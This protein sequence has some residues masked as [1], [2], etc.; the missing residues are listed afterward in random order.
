MKNLNTDIQASNRIISIINNSKNQYELIINE[1]ENA[2]V[3]INDKYEILDANQIISSLKKCSFLRENFYS[4]IHIDSQ[5]ELSQVISKC[6]ESEKTL[7]VEGK[8]IDGR[9]FLFTISTLHINRTE[10]GKV[11]K[12]LGTDITALREKEGLI[13]DIFRSV[14]LGMVLIDENSCIMNGYSNFT[15]IILESNELEGENIFDLLFDKNQKNYN[16]D[17]KAALEK[18][19]NFRGTLSKD[20]FNIISIGLPKMI[21]IP[22]M[23]KNEGKTVFKLSYESILIDNTVKRYLLILQDVTDYVELNPPTF[24]DDIAKMSKTYELDSDTYMTIIEQVELINEGVSFDPSISEKLSDLKGDLHTIKGLLRFGGLLY[25]ANIVHEIED[26]L[27]S[28]NINFEELANKWSKYLEDWTKVQS[29]YQ[30]FE[31]SD[32]SEEVKNSSDTNEELQNFKGRHAIFTPV[33]SSN[34]DNLKLTSNLKN[35]CQRYIENNTGDFNIDVALNID[36][37]STYIA[38]STF[39]A[40]N[41]ILL[42]FINNSFAH[43]FDG[44]DVD[45]PQIDIRF[46]TS[47]EFITVDYL[48]NGPGVNIEKIR[49]KLCSSGKEVQHFSDDELAQNIFL[50]GL[51][52]KDSVDKVAGRG[53]GLSGVEAEVKRLDGNISLMKY[54]NGVHFQ[55]TLPILPEDYLG[56]EFITAV[57]LDETLE[58]YFSG[59]LTASDLNGLYR[60]KSPKGLHHA[61]MLLQ[62]QE[63]H[64]LNVISS[65]DEVVDDSYSQPFEAEQLNIAKQLLRTNNIHLKVNVKTKTYELRFSKDLSTQYPISIECSGKLDNDLIKNAK[66]LAKKMNIELKLKQS[67]DM[68]LTNRNYKYQLIKEVESKIFNLAKGTTK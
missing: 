4:Y 24:F 54:T 44:K 7:T 46:N 38:T 2:Y 28:H 43:A 16:N 52:T 17:E 26:S 15:K 66:N 3:I 57:T 33:L 18:L 31:N 19:R 67:S 32:V 51:S 37:N 21:E 27:G 58:H 13:M 42:H 63:E 56:H 6:F 36:D 9:L 30:S 48:D 14:S 10:E 22:S 11:L 35:E 53:A 65:K 23:M 41:T 1:L 45:N 60:L 68:K 25:L 47:D 29:I 61:L 40:L 34:F 50:T 55:V 62:H 59:R 8:L 49:E 12:L 20:D 39:F 64:K 5:E